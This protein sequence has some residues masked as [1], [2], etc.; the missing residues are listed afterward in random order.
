MGVTWSSTFTLLI[1]AALLL[2]VQRGLRDLAPDDVLN[3]REYDLVWSLASLVAL[4]LGT[5]IA[6][7]ASFFAIHLKEVGGFG[8][9]ILTTTLILVLA[10]LGG[11]CWKG[12]A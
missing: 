5:A 11:W 8:L 4:L 7:A 2:N 3:L 12:R 10:T 9:G 6:V 1:A